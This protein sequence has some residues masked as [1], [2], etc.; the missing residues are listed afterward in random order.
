MSSRCGSASVS[1]LERV[2]LRFLNQSKAAINATA[3]NIPMPTP[4]PILAPSDKPWELVAA[5]IAVVDAAA[6]ELIADLVSAID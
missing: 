2:L 6:D 1:N 3:A 5:A 4:M